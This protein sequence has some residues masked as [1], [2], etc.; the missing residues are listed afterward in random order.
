[1]VY[2][3]FK[4]VHFSF[5]SQNFFHK[6]TK[7]CNFFLP[8]LQ[9]ISLLHIKGQEWPGWYYV[10]ARI[11]QIN[12]TWEQKLKKIFHKM[13]W[14]ILEEMIRTYI[15]C[16][17]ERMCV[18]QPRATVLS[19]HSLFLSLSASLPCF[20]T[21]RYTGKSQAVSCHESCKSPPPPQQTS[22]WKSLRG[23]LAALNA[24]Y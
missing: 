23:K 19:K 10:G 5:L 18:H 24:K 21:R 14:K 16:A 15:V 12:W 22:C 17:L 7:I 2:L 20:H 1:M 11:F 3:P 6:I 8:T 4:T 13:P 9:S